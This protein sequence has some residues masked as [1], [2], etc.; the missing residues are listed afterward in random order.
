M[1]EPGHS[2]LSAFPKPLM[3]VGLAVTL[4]VIAEIGLQWLSYHRSGQSIFAKLQGNSHYV[5]DPGTGLTLL[6][7]SVEFGGAQQSIQSNS[8][9]LRSPEIVLEKPKATL[10]IAVLGASTV[11]GAYAA[12]NEGT[13]PARLEQ[14]LRTA[15]PGLQVEVINAGLPGF[16]LDEQAQLFDRLIARFSPDITIV[17][18]GFNDF[19]IYCRAPASGERW[20]PQPLA[21]VA[22]PPWLLSVELLLKNSVSI[23]T[24]PSG[25]QPTIDASTL[26]LS[27]YTG[28]LS[29]LMQTL[30]S[31]GTQVLF[32]RNARSY[33]PDQPLEV[34]LDLST[35]ARFY[36][37]CFDLQGLHVLYDRHNA[38]IDQVAKQKNIAV[39][40]MDRAIPGG[41]E[42][43]VDASHFSERGEQVAAEWL[44]N[45]LSAMSPPLRRG[46]SQ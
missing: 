29:R 30:Q 17:Y 25:L 46:A 32:A 38:A 39:L 22:L 4:F 18:P 5:P 19:G 34:Q 23:R 31:H 21:R 10:R 11:F 14:T 33:R 41:P 36:N 24:L 8:Y 43:F 13:F 16:G 26:D 28:R 9:G 12:N 2:L 40:P 20:Q 6:R 45:Y 15:H 3:A 27:A 42:Y 37:P 35:T 1:R 7:P 44:A